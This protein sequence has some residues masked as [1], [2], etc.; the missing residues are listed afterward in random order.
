MTKWL[1]LVIAILLSVGIY[2][3]IDNQAITK[4]M[5]GTTTVILEPNRKLVSLSWKDNNL[6]VLSRNMEPRET[7]DT[8]HYD[9][10][11]RFGVLEGRVIVIESKVKGDSN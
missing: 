9:E 8:Y 7:P 2:A 6:W 4:T 10:R 11:S 1:W 3:G 5:G